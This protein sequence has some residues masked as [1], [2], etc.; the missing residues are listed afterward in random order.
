MS[1]NAEVASS[2]RASPKTQIEDMFSPLDRQQGSGM[3][4]GSPAAANGVAEGNTYPAQARSG[5]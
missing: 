4:P 1:D 3:R 5:R 2:I